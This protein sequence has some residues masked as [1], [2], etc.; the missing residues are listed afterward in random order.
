MHGSHVQH[1][2][3]KFNTLA[4]GLLSPTTRNFLTLTQRLVRC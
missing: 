4:H 3:I 2:P 1:Q